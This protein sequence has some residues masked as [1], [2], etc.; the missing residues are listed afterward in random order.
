MFYE[1]DV[2]NQDIGAWNVSQGTNFVSATII[3][4]I[5]CSN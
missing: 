2:F 1:A 3:I 5:I 4:V